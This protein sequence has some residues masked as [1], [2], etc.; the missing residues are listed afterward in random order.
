MSKQ[1]EHDVDPKSSA[2]GVHPF[3]LPAGLIAYQC[4]HLNLSLLE[5]SSSTRIIN[6]MAGRL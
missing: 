1:P 2:P 3:V 5:S 4:C 6:P